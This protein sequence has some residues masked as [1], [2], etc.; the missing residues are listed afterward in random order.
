MKTRLILLTL[1]CLL[2][3]A[4]ATAQVNYVVVSG[5]GAFVTSS[6]NASGDIVIASTYLGNPVTYI[7]SSAFSGCTNLTN[8][9]F[10]GNAPRLVSDIEGG[11]AHFAGVGAGA[12][13]YYYRGTTG[14]G[15]N[16]GYP[17]TVMLCPPQI[18][19]GSAG[20][21]PGGFGFTLTRLTNQTIVVEGQR[22]PGELA[23]HL[24]QHP[25]RRLRR[26]CRS[27]MGESPA[28]LLSRALGLNASKN[29]ESA[30]PLATL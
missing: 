1:A 16:F 5:R 4:P 17:P 29:L 2:V 27:R 3:A 24:D 10:L 18:A 12:K 20:T 23:T 14:W 8:F 7:V 19:P 30:K 13:A 15:Q 11:A 22:Q 28:P 9:T 25:V 26:F 21:K 6:P